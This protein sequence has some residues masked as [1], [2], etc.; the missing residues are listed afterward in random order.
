MESLTET[1]IEII[2]TV[3][4]R[5]NL[6]FSDVNKD[7]NKYVSSKI[8]DLRIDDKVYLYLDNISSDVPFGI[9]Y[10][11]GKSVSE[12]KFKESFDLDKL[13]IIFKNARGQLYNFNGLPHSLSFLVETQK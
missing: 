2:P 10:F 4:S 1:N 9:L 5:E 3:L 6:G 7:A 13:T 11:N 8:W 12:F